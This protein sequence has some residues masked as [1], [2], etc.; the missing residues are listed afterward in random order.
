ML[1]IAGGDV[2]LQHHQVGLLTN[3]DA[4]QTVFTQQ[5]VGLVQGGGLNHLLHSNPFGG[6]V[7]GL[8]LAGHVAG[9]STG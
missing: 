1:G 6:P 9:F 5:L 7:Q 4:A 2:L 8:R 3:G